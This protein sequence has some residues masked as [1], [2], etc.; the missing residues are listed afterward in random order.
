MNQLL[1]L[2]AYWHTFIKKD[3]FLYL[4]HYLEWE[5]EKIVNTIV[6][7]YGWENQKIPIPLGGLVMV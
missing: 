3:D 2:L 5:E 4:Y 6:K 7:E 1:I